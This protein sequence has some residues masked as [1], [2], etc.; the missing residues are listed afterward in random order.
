MVSVL[1]RIDSALAGRYD[2]ADLECV[3]KALCME[4]L[5]MSQLQYYT[6]ETY[7]PDP[8]RER[9]LDAALER[10][11]AGEPLQH[12][13]GTAQFM[14]LELKV[15][16][17][18]LVPRPET[19]GL[20]EWVLSDCGQTGTLLDIGTGSGCIAISLSHLLPLWSVQAWDISPDALQVAREN[21]LKCGTKVEF[22]Q[23]DILSAVCSDSRFDVIVSNPPYVTQSEKALMEPVVLDY[24]PHLALFVPDDDALRFYRAISDFA[25]KSLNSGG[26]LYFE[27][28]PLFAH[29]LK[30][31]LERKGYRNVTLRSDDFGKLRYI[32]ADTDDRK[33]RTDKG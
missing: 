31:M 19:A 8:E 21:N 32:K 18:V 9:M 24:E 13:L 15:D 25:M 29:E 23:R 11:A 1:E 17:R 6:G 33:G 10:L 28:N 20:V 27:I 26:R 2:Y 12:V 4:L 30:D 3:R 7:C 5:G 22:R 14:G 16:G